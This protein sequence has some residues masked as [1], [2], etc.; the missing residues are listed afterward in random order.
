MAVLHIPKRGLEFVDMFHQ[1]GVFISFGKGDRE[2]PRGPRDIRSTIARQGDS[3]IVRC[4][5]ITIDA[6]RKAHYILPGCEARI[7]L[8][9]FDATVRGCV[10]HVSS[11]HVGTLQLEANHLMSKLARLNFAISPKLDIVL[12]K[13]LQKAQQRILSQICA[14]LVTAGHENQ[15]V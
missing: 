3:S 13:T 15:T 9:E 5:D 6:V 4:E 11:R 1:Q 14:V 8:A 12:L 10:N 2:E 7:R